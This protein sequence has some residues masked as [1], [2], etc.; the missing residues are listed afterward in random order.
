MRHLFALALLGACSRSAPI[1]PTASAAPPAPPDCPTDGATTMELPAFPPQARLQFMTRDREGAWRG[2][3][4]LEDQQLWR[5]SR[6]G[7]WQPDGHLSDAQTTAIRDAIAT[8]ALAGRPLRYGSEPPP[9]DAAGWAL[10]IWFSDGQLEFGGLGCRPG[11]VDDLV[12]TI[13]PQLVPH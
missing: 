2:F 4:L 3:R 9:D 1:E 8:A 6:Q 11:F 5:T 13:A 10:Q 7:E 12:S